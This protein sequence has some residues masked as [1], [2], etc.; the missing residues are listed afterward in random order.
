M[1]PQLRR[2]GCSGQ[3]TITQETLLAMAAGTSSFDFFARM[4]PSTWT[5][6]SFNPQTREACVLITNATGERLVSTSVPEI[7]PTSERVFT[8]QST[9][10]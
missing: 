6:F 3:Q 8:A 7:V 2:R 10:S 1:N 5:V 9:F 4:D